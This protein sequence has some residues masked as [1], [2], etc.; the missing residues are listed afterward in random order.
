[1]WPLRFVYPT[2]E[3]DRFLSWL[4]QVLYHL[5]SNPRPKISNIEFFLRTGVTFKNRGNRKLNPLSSL[6]N[7]LAAVYTGLSVISANLNSPTSFFV[8]HTV[9]TYQHDVQVR[10]QIAYCPVLR[11]SHTQTVFH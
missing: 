10:R 6:T 2:S 8:N 9:V 11:H 5:G 3:L 1:M 7:P 4:P